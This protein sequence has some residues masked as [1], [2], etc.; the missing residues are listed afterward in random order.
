MSVIELS[1]LSKT[2]GDTNVVKAVNSVDLKIEKGEFVVILGPSG[3]GKTTL[4]NL[5]GGIEAA[6]QGDV[7]VDKQEL[8]RLNEDQRTQFRRESIGIIFQFYN[9]IPT[10]T[11]IE[12][13]ELIAELVDGDAKAESEKMLKKVGLSDRIMHFPS[14][15]SGGQQQ[16]VAIA[17]AIVKKPHLLLCDEPTGAMDVKTGSSILTLLRDLNKKNEQT[18][19]LVTHNSAISKIADRVVKMQDG[20]IVSSKKNQKPLNPK[21]VKW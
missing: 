9:L 3:C 21:N 13:V 16:R 18:V 6:S 11:A 15:L 4:L 14:A 1:N 8:A 17:R 12:N 2:Y 19:L 5:I 20:K 10:L 7:T